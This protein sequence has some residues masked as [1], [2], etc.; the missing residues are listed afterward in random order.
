MDEITT[1]TAI[2]EDLETLLTFE[3]GII[4]AERP[5]DE[6]LKLGQI[7]YY[8]IRQMILETETEVA[9]AEI[10][11]RIVGS[12]YAKIIEAK[13]YY[14]FEKYAY[15]GFMY[16]DSDFRGLGINSKIIQYLKD[17]CISQNVN[18]MR[19]DVYETNQSAVKAYEKYGF[20]KDMV[21]MRISI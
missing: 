7:S 16:T 13:P 5:F 18:E 10:N 4:K 6:T 9:V 2:L 3:Q 19:L 17:W 21:N 12:G 15:L 14:T 1:R 8:D 20:K 11:D